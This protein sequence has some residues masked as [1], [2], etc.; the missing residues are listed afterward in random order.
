MLNFFKK[1]KEPEYDITNITIHDLD[2]GFIL[3][4]DLK[5]WVVKE[6]YEYEPEI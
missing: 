4:Y 3:D 2:F 6:V 5:S 1:K